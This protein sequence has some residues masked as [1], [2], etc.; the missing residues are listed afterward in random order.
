MLTFRKQYQYRKPADGEGVEPGGAEVVENK[1]DAQQNEPD[2][3]QQQVEQRARAMGWTP[4]DQFKGDP[5]KWREAAEFVERGER[6]MPLM[7]AQ[8]KRLEAK[9]AELSTAIK[10]MGDFMSKTEQRAYDRALSELKAQR[11]EA[12]AAGDGDTFEKVDDAIEK[13]KREAAEAAAKHKQQAQEP[14]EDPVYKEWESRNKWLSDP[15][16]Q[17]Y[18][19]FAAQRL[20]NGGERSQGA[21]FL[22]MVTQKVKAKYPEKFTNPRRETA[23]SVEGAA[24]APRKGGKG[25]ADMPADAKAACERM[26]KNA[27]AGDEKA[28]AK[29]KADYVKN[30]FE[31]A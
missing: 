3:A 11:K 13:I 26:A 14:A 8:N 23:N 5:S 27:F 15:D 16:M 20:R 22:D 21:E 10:D 19:E 30:Y 7:R 12:L 2:E 17:E 25:F 4:K 31:E 1:Q 18:A 24:P 9:V 28:M 29:F 6:E